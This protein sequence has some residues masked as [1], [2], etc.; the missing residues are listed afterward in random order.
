M[1]K[2]L[3]MVYGVFHYLVLPASASAS[4]TTYFSQF[5][6][7]SWI[8]SHGDELEEMSPSP[9]VTSRSHTLPFLIWIMD[10]LSFYVKVLCKYNFHACF[11][12]LFLQPEGCPQALLCRNSEVIMLNCLPTQN[13]P[14]PFRSPYHMFKRFS[15]PGIPHP[16]YPPLLKPIDHF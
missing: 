5:F 15:F 11:L 7:L 12:A 16:L 10:S 2:V 4:S 13:K 14:F 8:Y 3:H 6:R 9:P 1:R